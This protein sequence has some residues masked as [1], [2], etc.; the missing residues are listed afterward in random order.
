MEYT[1]E[2]QARIDRD[3]ASPQFL[4]YAARCEAKR[5][6]DL[7]KHLY[8]DDEMMIGKAEFAFGLICDIDDAIEHK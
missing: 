1:D 7:V 5:L 8:A 4:S 6:L 3:L 2:E